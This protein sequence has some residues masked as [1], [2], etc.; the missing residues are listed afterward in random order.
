MSKSEQKVVIFENQSAKISSCHTLSIFH[1]PIFPL[2]VCTFHTFISHSPLFY[3]L[4]TLSSSSQLNAFSVKDIFSLT[5]IHL[6]FQFPPAKPSLPPP[7]PSPPFLLH[8][9][10]HQGH[11][12][13]IERRKKKIV[14][15]LRNALLC[16]SLSSLPLP[17]APPFHRDISELTSPVSV[18]AGRHWAT[19]GRLTKYERMNKN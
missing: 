15:M 18:R 6:V 14:W 9:L 12:P 10:S 1:V 4:S 17:P 5:S 11:T 7:H 19:A 8:I 3:L 13:L 16:L 2:P